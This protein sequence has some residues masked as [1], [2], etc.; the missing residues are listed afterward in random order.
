MLFVS[1][2]THKL[3]VK[4][5]YHREFDA[6]GESQMIVEVSVSDLKPGDALRL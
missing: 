4:S 5:D 3:Y 6:F 2:Y 1:Q